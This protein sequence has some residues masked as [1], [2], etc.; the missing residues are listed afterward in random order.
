MLMRNPAGILGAVMLTLVAAPALGQNVKT[1]K[2][3]EAEVRYSDGCVVYYAKNGRR[4]DSRS[5]CSANQNRRADEAMAAYRRQHG[6]SG[7][8]GAPEVAVDHQGAG[9]VEFDSGCVVRYDRDG[10][11]AKALSR[12]TDNEIKRA[13]RAIAVARQH[14]QMGSSSRTATGGQLN[15]PEGPPVGPGDHAWS[16]CGY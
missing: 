16:R 15:C 14:E 1:Q 2:N 9:R 7:D 8:G 3:G 13:D 5:G 10:H 12:C 11:R 6:S 4:T